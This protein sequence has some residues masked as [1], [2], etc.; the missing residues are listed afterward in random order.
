MK[1]S[2]LKKSSIVKTALSQTSD[3]KVLISISTL[4]RSH[5]TYSYIDYR[6]KKQL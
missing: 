1:H 3:P 6:N 4:F 2:E 5:K